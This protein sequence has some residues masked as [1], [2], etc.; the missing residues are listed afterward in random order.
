MKMRKFI[1][2][3]LIILSGI[4]YANDDL[5]YQLENRVNE[6]TDKIEKL[7]HQ[8]NVLQKKLDSLAEDVEFRMK[9]IENKSNKSSQEKETKSVKSADPKSSKVKFDEAYALLTSQKYEEAEN[10]FSSFVS[11]YP[12]SEYTGPAYY[13]LGESFMLRKRYDKA[14]VNYLQ[15][16][17]KFPKN[18]KADLSTLKLASALHALGKKKDSCA[19]LAKLKAKNDSL[20]GAMQNL[21]KKETAK[22]GCK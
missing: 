8:N 10:A 19:M 18:S 15:S 20:S 2:S 21:L 13:W 17:S 9:G 5:V 16:F 14:A 6:L 22:L 3:L 1:F 4:A 12:K 7:E 11:N